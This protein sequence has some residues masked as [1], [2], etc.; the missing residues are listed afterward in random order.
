MPLTDSGGSS[1][2]Y[3]TT[4]SLNPLPQSL[5]AITVYAA[6]HAAASA[7][8][9]AEASSLMDCVDTA[10]YAASPDAITI[11]VMES[12]I[13]AFGAVTGLGRGRGDVWGSAG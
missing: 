11:A 9:A 1:R 7:A 2:R 4:I 10:A 12:Y 13:A 5:P 3:L 6:T 8:Y